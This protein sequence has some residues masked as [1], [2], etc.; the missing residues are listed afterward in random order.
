MACDTDDTTAQCS[1]STLFSNRCVHRTER[2]VAN[3]PRSKKGDTHD[4]F[5]ISLD[6]NF[7]RLDDNSE[8]EIISSSNLYSLHNYNPE[9]KEQ[10]K[11]GEQAPA[12]IDGFHCCG[13][14]PDWWDEME[15]TV[16]YTFT[17][18]KQVLIAAFK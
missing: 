6:D 10:W 9:M 18:L 8:H 15:G 16:K 17:S 12:L 3:I 1:S 11:R 4:C 13:C 7:E 2:F 14:C 5:G